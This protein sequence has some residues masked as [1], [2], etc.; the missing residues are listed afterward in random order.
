ME[1]FITAVLVGMG[2]GVLIIVLLIVGA[3][4]NRKGK[5]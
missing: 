3:I 5:A 2:I 1:A 4:R